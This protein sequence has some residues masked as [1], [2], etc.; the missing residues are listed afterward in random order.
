MVALEL[1]K[2]RLFDRVAAGLVLT[3][4]GSQLR[5][6]P[7][8]AE[9]HLKLPARLGRPKGFT[10]MSDLIG[11]PAYATSIGLVEHSLR[12]DDVYEP[13]P[14]FDVN[15]GGLFKRIASLGRALMPQ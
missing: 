11:T 15:A 4:G 12:E 14:G 7:E 1:R 9:A 10:G 8:V 3:G 13:A 6:L 2:Y 5:G